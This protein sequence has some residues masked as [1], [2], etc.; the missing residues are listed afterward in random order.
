[1]IKSQ[2][3]RILASAIITS[4]ALFGLQ[5]IALAED[6]PTTWPKDWVITEDKDEETDITWLASPPE[7]SEIEGIALMLSK[8]KI[9]EEE[10]KAGLAA[11][12]KI[13]FGSMND[14]SDETTT[15]TCS[16]PSKVQV[17]TVDALETSCT[18]KTEDSSVKQL[19]VLSI[20]KDHMYNLIFSGAEA[21]VDAQ[22]AI[23]D[24]FKKNT[25]IE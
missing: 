12:F 25:K 1:M 24:E 19:I 16:E 10:A 9:S 22:L 2:F 23:W 7:N 11:N 21:D 15:V 8:M 13:M 6:A 18:T 14:M 5:R 3:S 4:F 17:G 20:S